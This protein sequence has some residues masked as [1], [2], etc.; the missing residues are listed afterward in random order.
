MDS[1]F[2]IPFKNELSEVERLHKIVSEY[3]EKHRIPQDIQMNLNLAIEELLVNTITYGFTDN[4]TH[5]IF[6]RFYIKDHVLI[7]EMEDDGIAFNPLQEAPEPDFNAPV[8]EKQIGGLGIHFVKTLID[9]IEYQRKDNKN[10]LRLK[11]RLK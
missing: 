6:M 2:T 5:D 9:E 1:L 7:A 8:E 11:K 10:F 4:E 3:C